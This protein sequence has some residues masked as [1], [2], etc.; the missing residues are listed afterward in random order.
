MEILEEQITIA[1]IDNG[2]PVNGMQHALQFVVLRKPVFDDAIFIN[3]S[4]GKI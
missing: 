3:I 2:Y 4:I 1:A